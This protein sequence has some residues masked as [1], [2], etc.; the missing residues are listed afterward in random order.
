VD[1]SEQA[2]LHKAYVYEQPPIDN[3]VLDDLDIRNFGISAL[4]KKWNRTPF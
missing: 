1:V 4:E 2:Q 3:L